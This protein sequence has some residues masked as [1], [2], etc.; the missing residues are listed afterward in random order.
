MRRMWLYLMRPES[1]AFFMVAGIVS[2]QTDPR[3]LGDGIAT[4]NCSG[5]IAPSGGGNGIVNVDDLL[6]V[7]NAWGPCPLPCSASCSADINQ[8]C[9]VNVDDLLAVI[10]GWGQCPACPLDSLEPDNS[11][12]QFSMLATVG[13][14]QTQTY[15]NLNLHDSSDEDYFKI[16]AQETDSSCSCCDF[17]CTDENFQLKI[18][19]TVPSQSA[20]GYQFCTGSSCA[21][22]NSNCHT[23]LPGQSYTWTW[24]LDGGCPQ[25]DSYTYY[26]RIAAAA[27]GETGCVPYTLQYNFVPG[28]FFGIDSEEGDGR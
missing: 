7:I 11:C 6:A 19:L 3:A 10:N 13:S 12:S 21:G 22:V 5:D 8:N 14:N 28:C 9:T 16:F 26:I 20:V 25:M 17:W 23:V 1:I 2:I 27:P 4:G 15:S 18:S 24:T